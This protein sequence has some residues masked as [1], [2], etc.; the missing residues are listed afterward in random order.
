[1][2]TSK[3]TNCDQINGLA[4]TSTGLHNV[5]KFN[6]LITNSIAFKPPSQ[7]TILYLLQEINSEWSFPT[8]Y[9]SAIHLFQFKYQKLSKL[10]NYCA[11]QS[12]TVNSMCKNHAQNICIQRRQELFDF[13]CFGQSKSWNIAQNIH[14]LIKISPVKYWRVINVPIQ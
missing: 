6:K 13:Q 12:T 2:I 1:M 8:P 7:D 11:L 10:I 14:K 5:C 3:R 4:I 9:I